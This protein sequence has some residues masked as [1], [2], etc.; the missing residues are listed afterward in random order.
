MC[1]LPLLELERALGAR[2]GLVVVIG[3]LVPASQR[4]TSHASCRL[5]QAQRWHLAS[6]ARRGDIS[7]DY[8]RR[9][10]LKRT[11]HGAHTKKVLLDF[12]ISRNKLNFKFN[13]I[14][15]NF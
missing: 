11:Y 3:L 7:L 9:L 6:G 8:R 2:G 1:C 12:L 14:S 13:S 4:F 5:R 15:I 10:T